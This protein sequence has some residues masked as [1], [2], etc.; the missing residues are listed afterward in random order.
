MRDVL[1]RKSKLLKIGQRVFW[2]KK[3]NKGTVVLV[4]SDFLQIKWDNGKVSYHRHDSMQ[5]ISLVR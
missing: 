3:D 4:N 5:D 2:R 1:P